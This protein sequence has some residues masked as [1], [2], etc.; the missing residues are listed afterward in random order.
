MNDIHGTASVQVTTAALVDSQGVIVA[1]DARWAW[2]GAGQDGCLAEGYNV[3]DSLL[4]TFEQHETYLPVAAS[5]RAVLNGA[6]ESDHVLVRAPADLVDKHEWRE[7]SVRVIERIG[8]GS[9]SAGAL[10]EVALLGDGPDEFRRD[11]GAE[12]RFSSALSLVGT[13]LAAATTVEEVYAVVAEGAC[14]IAGTD[15]AVLNLLDDLGATVVNVAVAGPDAAELLGHRMPVDSCVSGLVIRT[16]EPV[17]IADCQSDERVWRPAAVPAYVS[18]AICVPLKDQDN[19]AFGVIAVSNV[20]GSRA[21]YR[22]CL[23]EMERFAHHAAL[24]LTTA[25]RLLGVIPAIVQTT[26]ERQQL[27][28]PQPDELSRI[29]SIWDLNQTEFARHVGVSRQAVDRWRNQIP[30]ERRGLL[31]ELTAATE[32]LSAHIPNPQIPGFVQ[33]RH[34]TLNNRALVD[35]ID[36]PDRSLSHAVLEVIKTLK[37]PPERSLTMTPTAT[38]Q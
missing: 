2:L 22:G 25:R 29:L 26:D 12:F 31:A 6:S 11:R 1:H 15:A 17:T 8:S 27:R 37:P 9:E 21:L 28:N 23:T 35:F 14:L 24:G 10:V 3:G 30:R 18:E 16:G 38:E 4:A 34:P 7:L 33:R 32:I 5:L 19:T 20:A 36:D 13:A